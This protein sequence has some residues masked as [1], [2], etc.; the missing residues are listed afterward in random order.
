ME[1]VTEYFASDGGYPRYA[2]P[3]DLRV[4]GQWVTTDIQL[5]PNS[6]LE[7]AALVAA[8]RRNPKAQVEEFGGNAHYAEISPDGVR[9]QNEHVDHVQGNFTVDQAAA[10]LSDF[11]NYCMAVIPQ[12][13]QEAR[14]AF[15]AEHGHDPVPELA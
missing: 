11:W 4:L 12:R 3:N 13:A 2:G 7:V 15:M 5:A 8:A 9:I 10:V 6:L 1:R 14:N